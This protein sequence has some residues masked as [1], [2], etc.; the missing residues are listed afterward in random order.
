MSESPNVLKKQIKVLIEE[1]KKKDQEISHLKKKLKEFKGK[2]RR[3]EKLV[4]AMKS[5]LRSYTTK[6]E[7]RKLRRKDQ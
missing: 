6:K 3:L 1:N 5:S 7:K 2:S 4:D